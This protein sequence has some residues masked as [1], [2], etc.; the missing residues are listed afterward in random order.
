M[1]KIGAEGMPAEDD[2]SQNTNK[3]SVENMN[4]SKSTEKLDLT[5]AYKVHYLSKQHFDYL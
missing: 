3:W 1:A 5:W 2:E 4:A